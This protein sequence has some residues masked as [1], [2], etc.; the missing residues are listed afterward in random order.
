MNTSTTNSKKLLEM[1]WLE[2]DEVRKFVRGEL[3]FYELLQTIQDNLMEFYIP[4][5][6]YGTAKARTGD[7]DIWIA[8]R[9]AKYL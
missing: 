9:L 4:L 3:D 7:P 5:M 8:D 2:L 6:P 1:R